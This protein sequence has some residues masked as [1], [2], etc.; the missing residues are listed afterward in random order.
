MI[1]GVNEAGHPQSLNS[2][3]I[4]GRY[5]GNGSGAS[6]TGPIWTAAM[7]VIEKWLPDL[8]FQVPSS[9]DIKGLLIQIP[10]VYGMDP[11]AAQ[12]KL[13]KAGFN[14][15]ISPGQVDSSYPQGTVAY[16]SPGSGSTTGSGD[17]VTIYLSDGTPPP[18]PP[19]PAPKK[20]KKDATATPTTVQ[21]PAPPKP[22][23]GHP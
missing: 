1:A 17:L 9:T 15:A 14:V 7:S 13:E 12:A 16:T 6:T 3:S 22:G 10:S 18:P 19:P 4:G 5:I 2:H 11:A 23:G 8:D 20:K 21:P